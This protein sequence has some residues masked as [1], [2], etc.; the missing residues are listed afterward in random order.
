MMDKR[1]RKGLVRREK[2]KWGCNT[3]ELRLREL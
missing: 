1:I 2:G 3:K